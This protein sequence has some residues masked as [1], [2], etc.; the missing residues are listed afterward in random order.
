V[1][2]GIDDKPAALAAWLAETGIDAAETVYVGND[3]NDLG[4]M[5]MVGLACAPADA[6]PEALRAAAYVS[7]AGGGRGAV[8]DICERIIAFNQAADRG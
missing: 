5:A 4:C 7:P 6:R 8:R 1:L 3:V 2:H